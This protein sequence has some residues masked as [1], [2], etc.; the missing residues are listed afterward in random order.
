VISKAELKIIDASHKQ[1]IADWKKEL[2]N[3]NLPE[4]TRSLLEH[5]VTTMEEN[6]NYTYTS[7][8]C[9]PGIYYC[10][11][12]EEP[13]LKKGFIDGID[14]VVSYPWPG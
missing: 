1:M 11:L 7:T 9:W 4:H 3:P 14:V 5:M 8:S 6:L 13:L 2:E 10:E 12:P